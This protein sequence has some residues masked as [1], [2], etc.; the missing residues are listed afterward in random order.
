MWNELIG[1]FERPSLSNKLQ[2]L[3]RL[4]DI[5][6][7]LSSS[8]DCYF[9]QLQELTKRLAA[10]DAPVEPD[11]QVALL[12]RGLPSQYDSR[13]VAFVAKGNVSLSELREAL[14]TEECRL[15]A[16]EHPVQLF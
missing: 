15:S 13:R 12:L 11:L 8:V 3:T 9:K 16:V 4:L 7:E 14:R 10:L 1:T 6:M 5:K 2:S